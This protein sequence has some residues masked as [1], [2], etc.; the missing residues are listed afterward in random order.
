M[1]WKYEIWDLLAL[2]LAQGPFLVDRWEVLAFLGMLLTDRSQALVGIQGS[3]IISSWKHPVHASQGRSSQAQ[4][5]AAG[6]EGKILD[7]SEFPST[8]RG[9]LR[10]RCSLLASL[11]LNTRLLQVVVD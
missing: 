8:T 9:S 10:F 5:Q 6:S 1:K 7:T 11:G 4:R 2:V 3:L